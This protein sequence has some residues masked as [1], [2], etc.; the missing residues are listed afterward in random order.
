MPRRPNGS[1]SLA[2]TATRACGRGRRRTCA[3]LLHVAAPGLPLPRPGTAVEGARSDRRCQGRLHP[4]TLPQPGPTPPDVCC[5]DRIDVERD[6]QPGAARGFEPRGRAWLTE[7]LFPGHQCDQRRLACSVGG[8]PTGVIV[9][10][11][12]AWVA[13]VEETKRM[14][15]TDKAILGMVSESPG[16]NVSEPTG[17]LDK[18]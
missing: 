11:P 7:L 2:A 9:R 17:G 10:N 5:L 14:K 4:K 8:S 3:H 18:K 13:F 12:V 15:P 6:R 1:I 16:R